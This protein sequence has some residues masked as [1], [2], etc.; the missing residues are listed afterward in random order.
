MS[1]KL[2]DEIS[3]ATGCTPNKGETAAQYTERACDAISKLKDDDFGKLSEPAR[4][5][6]DDCVDPINKKEW[7]KLPALDGFVAVAADAA[8]PAAGDAKTEPAAARRR[9]TTPVAAPAAAKAADKPETAAQKKKRVAKEKKDAAAKKKA[10]AKAAKDA[11]EQAAKD[12]AA[13]KKADAKAKAEAKKNP[14]QAQFAGMPEGSRARTDSVAFKVRRAVVLLGT[15]CTFEQALKKANVTG[16]KRGG[17]GWN[18]YF[19][20]IQ[21]LRIAAAE[22]AYKTP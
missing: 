5:W 11:K 2:F 16:E 4:K 1:K 3:K 12:A 20:S 19:N 15:A 13:K 22:K 9:T 7:D 17:N 6:F 10:D 21:V 18:A 8:A 14:K